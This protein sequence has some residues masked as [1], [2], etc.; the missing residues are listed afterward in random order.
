MKEGA[1]KSCRT[2]GKKHERASNECV[3]MLV[4]LCDFFF[5]MEACLSRCRDMLR[6]KFRRLIK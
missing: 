6:L 4:L 2:G 5:N 1:R 3:L